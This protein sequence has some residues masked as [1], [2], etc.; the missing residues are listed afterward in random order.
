MEK[1]KEDAVIKDSFLQRL[2]YNS[3]PFHIV[4]YLS[5]NGFEYNIE[6]ENIRP[7]NSVLWYNL[8]KEDELYEFLHYLNRYC[9]TQ[10]EA[11]EKDYF[12]NLSTCTKNYNGTLSIDLNRFWASTVQ[13]KSTRNNKRLISSFEEFKK[14]LK[15][16]Y[17]RNEEILRRSIREQK[18]LL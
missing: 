1:T 15:Y 18:D 8:S 11:F 10:F 2:K 14:Y 4:L 13:D 16:L 9:E 7:M 12:S 5:P 17:S 3:Q 6:T